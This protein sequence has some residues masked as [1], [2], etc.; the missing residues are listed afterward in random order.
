M[1][2]NYRKKGIFNSSQVFEKKTTVKKYFGEQRDKKMS[3]RKTA[4]SPSN[5]LPLLL[6]CIQ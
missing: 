1:D 2:K 4:T 5:Y 3:Q 6:Q